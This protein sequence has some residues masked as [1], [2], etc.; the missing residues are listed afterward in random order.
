MYESQFARIRRRIG[1]GIVGLG[2][3]GVMWM[4]TPGLPVMFVQGRIDPS[5]RRR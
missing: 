5:L 3:F 2:A 4:F 1:M